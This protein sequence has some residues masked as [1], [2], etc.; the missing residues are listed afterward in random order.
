M[1]RKIVLAFV[2]F[3]LLAIGILTLCQAI[4]LGNIH[5]QVCINALKKSALRI[6]ENADSQSLRRIADEISQKYSCKIYLFDNATKNVLDLT[7]KDITG[8]VIDDFSINL[9]ADLSKDTEEAGGST[10]YS[11]VYDSKKDLY[12]SNKFTAMSPSSNHSVV[13]TLYVDGDKPYTVFINMVVTPVDTMLE[14]SR[15]MMLAVSIVMIMGAVL[16]AVYISKTI[17]KPIININKAAASLGQS[18]FNADFSACMSRSSYKEIEELAM[19]LE[20]AQTELSKTDALRKELIANVSHDLRTPLTLISGYS[21]MMKDFPSEINAENL[22][23]IVDECSRLTSLVEDMLEISK[24]E[25]GNIPINNESFDLTS[26]IES[27]V[28]SYSNM[29]HHNAYK[30]IFDPSEKLFV[31]SDRKMTMQAFYNLLNNALTYTGEDRTVTIRQSLNEGFVKIEVCDTGDGIPKENLPLV[32]D[33]YY[34]IPSEHKRSARGTGLG[35]SIVRN[36]ITAMGGHYGV[37]SAV[38]F[39]STFWFELPRASE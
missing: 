21:E 1:Q 30:I 10:V 6:S 37:R 22:Q 3:T 24:L 39:G 14:A 13:H 38:G 15:Y 29:L 35:L 8:C 19:T 34:K 25:S 26:K 11:F 28:A 32:F 36:V 16:L 23:T 20:S 5:N 2:T 12:R 18:N 9:L 17:A 33:R 31:H 4:F 7:Q 27:A